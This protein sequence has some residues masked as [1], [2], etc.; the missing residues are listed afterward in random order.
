MCGIIACLSLKNENI[1]KIILDG[2]ELLQNRG[3]DS[4]GISFFND[5]WETIK[6]ASSNISDSLKLLENKCKNINSTIAIGHTRWATHGA[7]NDI[8]SHPHISMNNK[9]ILVH[10]GIISNFK[11]IKDFLISKNY[12]FQSETDTEV[13]CN[14]IEY[15]LMQNNTIS[16][17]IELACNELEGSWALAIVHTEEQHNIYVTK[18]GSP[19]VLGKNENEVICTSEISSF[20]GRINNYIILNDNDLIKIDKNDFSYIKSDKY[21]LKT[22]DKISRNELSDEFKHWTIKEIYEQEKTID[23]ALNNG[24]RIY[25]DEIKLGGLEPYRNELMNIEHLVLLACGTSYHACLMAKYYFSGFNT[26]QAF[27]GSE[28]R[29]KDLP[30][31]GN[32]LAIFCSQSGETYD[33][34]QPIKYCKNRNCILMGIINVEESLIAREMNMGVY[35]NAG[36]ELAVPSTKSFTSMLIVLSIVAMYFRNQYENKKILLSLRNLSTNVKNLLHCNSF[37]YQSDI[38]TKFINSHLIRSIF[39]LG[40]GKLNSIALEGAL[41][42]KEMSYIHAEGYSGGSLKHGPFAILDSKALVILLIDEETREQSISTFHEIKSR[43]TNC[44]IITN[45]NDRD[46]LELSSNIIH[47]PYIKYYNEIL[48]IIALQYISYKLAISRNINPDKPR[49]LAKVV[50]VA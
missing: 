45:L 31:N 2:L 34:L 12:S 38:I 24:A 3:Y 23:L 40:R 39:V 28:F 48:F 5:K 42:I 6:Y 27:D 16:K 17:A 21:N 50:T 10:N 46:I 9:I 19:L 14:L 25:N 43:N 44:L 29:E 49:N 22:I 32:I 8:N 4:A 35:L 1:I 11:K 33:L 18:H 7:K 26:V 47:I 36:R 41:K 13:I 20:N 37:L 15:F 30:K